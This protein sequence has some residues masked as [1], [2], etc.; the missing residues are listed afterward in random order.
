MNKVISLGAGLKEKKLSEVRS[1][2][3]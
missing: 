3:R 2:Y 1:G